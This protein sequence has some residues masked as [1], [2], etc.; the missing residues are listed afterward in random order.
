MVSEI[1]K[2]EEMPTDDY[3]FT[4]DCC[5]DPH[6]VPNRM[7][8]GQTIESWINRVSV[9]VQRQAIE[10]YHTTGLDAAVEHVLG[11]IRRIHPNYADMIVAPRAHANP[12]Y[13]IDTLIQAEAESK[14]GI[15]LMIPPF[16]KHITP[17]KI[18]ELKEAYQVKI[19]PVTFYPKDKNNKPY[20]SR[21]KCDV[22]IGAKYMYILY[23]VPHA[24]APGVGY[25]NQFKVP[26][27]PSQYAKLKSLIGQTPL[28]IGEDETR[29]ST[30]C[31][32][33]EAVTRLMGMHANSFEAVK[34]VC[35]TLLRNPHPE[36]IP[37]MDITN[38]EISKSNNIIGV[39]KHL[40]STMG[41]NMD[42]IN[43]EA[44]D[45]TKFTADLNSI[46]SNK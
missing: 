18:I 44:F 46:Q 30:M 34:V 10:L 3:G 7:N 11:Y 37:R 27:K 35:N 23:K 5:I 42:N 6:A 20:K 8:P 17:E 25:I 38:E 14:V 28:R 1:R 21:T 13:F 22:A 36:N 29:I 33:A 4:V 40:M 9:F 41:I 16:L 26:V 2:T 15:Y 45:E 19:S 43:C 32:G 24:K 31:A 12:Q 39:A